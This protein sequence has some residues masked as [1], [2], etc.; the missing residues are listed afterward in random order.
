MGKHG[1]YEEHVEEIC[2]NNHRGKDLGDEYEDILDI[3]WEYGEHLD[4]Q[5]LILRK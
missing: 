4:Q 1:K 3:L 5:V 2:G